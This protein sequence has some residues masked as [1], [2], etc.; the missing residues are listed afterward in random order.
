MFESILTIRNS[1][2]A[3]EGSY[4]CQITS[5]LQPGYS[6]SVTANLTLFGKLI[7]SSHNALHF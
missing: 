1:E 3:D 2:R 6:H 5:A 4:T 7:T